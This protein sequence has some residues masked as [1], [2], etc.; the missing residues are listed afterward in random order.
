VLVSA[1]TYLTAQQARRRLIEDVAHQIAGLDVLLA[2]SAPV[3]APL[4]TADQVS[5]N[6]RLLALRPA[7]L[8]CVAPIS[9]LDC[10]SIS[11]PIG[12]A[13]AMPFGL[14]IFGRPFSEP[15]LLRVAAAVEQ[16]A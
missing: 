9:Q 1:S 8:S 3:T 4:L 6:G 7:L 5:V 15:L 13:D 2:P 16:L 10:P 11:V 12:I 14:Q